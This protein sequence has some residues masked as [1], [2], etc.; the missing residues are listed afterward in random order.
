MSNAEGRYF[1]LGMRDL[2]SPQN[3]GALV[4]SHVAF[5][6]RTVVFV[7]RLTPWR[8]TRHTKAFSRGFESSCDLITLPTD[9]ALFDWCRL[10]DCRSVALEI[11]AN[12]T[13]LNRFQFPPRSIIVVGHESFGLDT[14]FVERCD[15]NIKVQ[16]YG[17]VGSL[18]VSVAG[19]L[20]LYERARQLGTPARVLGEEFV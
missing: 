13:P 12:A 5:G 19:S 18:N 15:D 16:Q 2:K 6:G 17:P 9:D 4:R 11:G 10:N 8:F 1:A 14:A 3:I 20:A 7:G